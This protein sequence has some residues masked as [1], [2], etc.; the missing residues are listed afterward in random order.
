MAIIAG[1]STA[2][3]LT[4]AVCDALSTDL[5]C[6]TKVEMRLSASNRAAGSASITRAVLSYAGKLVALWRGGRWRS[7]FGWLEMQRIAFDEGGRSYRRLVGLCDVPD[8]DL[9]PARYRGRPA[10]VFRAGTEVGLQ[11]RA[12]W[13][14]G[15]LVRLGLL[16]NGRLME[17][18]ALLAQRLLRRIGGARSAMRI[19]LAGWRGGVAFKKRW[20]LLAERGD[21]PWVP[22]LAVPALLRRLSEGEID[23]G[24]RPASGLV[25]LADYDTGFAGL[26]IT[27]AI[28]EQPFRPLYERVM[29]K[30]FAVLTPAV[31]DMHRVVGEAYAEG[32]ATIVRGRNPLLRIA[33]WIFGFPPAGTDV[34]LRIWMDEN[35]G[36]ETWRRDFGGHE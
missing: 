18:P 15:W 11:N 20:D 2:P 5:D 27:H 35:D 34:P 22:A 9:V 10:T 6:I 17:R 28:E 3:A 29:E 21:G 8:H 25:G 24:A 30:D 19:D 1:A 4:A 14:T 32:A 16:G 7:G 31:Y 33:G 36:V 26:A 23:A 13:L 12:I